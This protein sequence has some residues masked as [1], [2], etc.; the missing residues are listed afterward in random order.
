M[1]TTIPK[2]DTLLE[3]FYHWVDTKPDFP[4]LKQPYGEVWKTLSYKEAYEE[5]AK[6][7]TALGKM[8]LKKGDHIAIFSKNCYHW[9]LADLAIMMGGY[10]SIPL[11]HNL[12]PGQLQEV[13]ELSDSKLLFAGKLDAWEKHAEMVPEDLPI[14]RFPHYEGNAKVTQGT[15]W[16]E[17]TAN[18]NPQVGRFIPDPESL[19]TIMF[20]SGTTGTPKGVMHLHKTPAQII[21]DDVK[22]DWI[23]VGRYPGSRLLSYLP[24]NHVGEKIGIYTTA[25]CIGGTI[26]FAE[27]I[28]TFADNLQYTQPNIFFAVPRIWTKFYLGVAS[29]IPL[30]AQNWLFKVPILSGIL[31]KS[32]KKKLGMGDAKIV[33]TGA[34]ITP[35]Y[36]KKWYKQFGL[37]LIEAYGMTEVC[38]SF[39]NSVELDCPLDTVGKVVPGCEVKIDPDSGE[40]LMRSPYMMEGYY[41]AP[42]LTAKVLKDGWLHSGDQGTLDDEGY[43]RI[44][45]RVSDAF[46][47]SKGKFVTPNPMEE[48]LGD[49]ELIEQVCVAG[50]GIPQPIAL[51]NLSEVAGSRDKDAIEEV[52]MGKLQEVNSRVANF[53]KVSTL[54]IDQETWTPEN[55]LITPTLKIRRQALN[56]KH[57]EH[58]LNW[59]NSKDTIIWLG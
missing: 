20:T 11:Y 51:V 31:K 17:L 58:F 6:M 29:K 57:G 27:S 59:H 50:L 22:N 54:V 14:I 48:T 46:K 19:W 55:E 24:L 38:G 3:Y 33:A 5:A 52:L 40:V 56:K 21:K 42:E 15:S 23:K 16:E 2:H 44:I 35:A 32:I 41:K 18:H 49:T 7:A 37:H 10:V 36:L 9:I 4:F 12:S 1:T 45:G 47:T 53:E 43:L 34:A 25:L 8:G 39:T 28:D 26:H 30:S 13:L